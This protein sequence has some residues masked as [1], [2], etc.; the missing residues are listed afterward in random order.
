MDTAT[1]AV[2]HWL[3][4]PL[5]LAEPAAEATDLGMDRR[6]VVVHC[7]AGVSRSA[8]IV[9]A[10]VMAFGARLCGP[11]VLDTALSGPLPRGAGDRGPL[12][13]ER[14]LSFVASRRPVISPNEG[15]L[16][17]LMAYERRLHAGTLE[18]DRWRH[19]PYATNS[20]LRV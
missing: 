17:Q 20:G 1:A 16:E 10:L 6:A 15:F 13:L 8:A 14:A 9:T 3:G 12:G 4:L 7:A 11:A 5:P 2:A 19:L 18:P